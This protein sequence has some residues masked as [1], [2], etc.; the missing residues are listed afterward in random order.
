MQAR[1]T[2]A[3]RRYGAEPDIAA[4]ANCCALNPARIDPS[5]SDVP[6]VQ[7]AAAR[8]AR[9]VERGVARMAEL[10]HEPVPAIEA[11]A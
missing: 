2:V 8:L 7:V 5:R 10:A 11:A 1:G 4:W 6:A 3:A 9:H